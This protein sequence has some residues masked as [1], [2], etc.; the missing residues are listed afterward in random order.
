MADKIILLGSG[1][2]NIVPK[3]MA[4]SVLIQKDGR[5][6]VFDFG[7]GTAIRLAELGV[8]QNE[9]TTIILSHLHPDHITDLYPF[10]HAASWSHVDSRD[11]DL[12][13]YGQPGTSSFIPK[14]LSVFGPEQLSR[15]FSIGTVD[16]TT[17]SPVEVEGLRL[18]FIDLHHSFG[19]KFENNGK[20]YAIMADSSLHDD[21]IDALRDVDLGIFDSGHLTDEEIIQLAVKSQAKQLVCSHQ[22]R[23]LD[24]AD[25]NEKA[26]SKGFT[27]QLVVGYDLMEY[28]L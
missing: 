19:M 9:V 16:L 23:E 20:Q 12:T 5:N 27:G 13:I 18:Q 7:R 28:L 24:Q 21:L 3:R 22:Y 11:T 1:S 8:K 10:L 25:L 2:C 17:A 15:H 4:A 26:R 14:L 6:I